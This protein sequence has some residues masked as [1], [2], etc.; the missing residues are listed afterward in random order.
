VTGPMTDEE[1][2]RRAWD[3]EHGGRYDIGTIDG[4]WHALRLGLGV[5]AM[6]TAAT[7]GDL[8]VMIAAAEEAHEK[9]GRASHSRTAG[10]A[11]GQ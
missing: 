7:P 5:E 10:H 9:C 3:A 8:A 6:L 2:V 4:M 1:R 11:G